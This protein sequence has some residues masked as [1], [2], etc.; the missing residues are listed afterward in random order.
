MNSSFL[1][2]KPAKKTDV[3]LDAV[4]GGVSSTG[5]TSNTFDGGFNGFDDVKGKLPV[6][7]PS[8]TVFDAGLAAGSS[9]AS[10]VDVKKAAIDALV[11]MGFSESNSKDALEK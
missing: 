9:S 10:A 5:K 7:A 4:F 2:G 1:S 6:P 11:G 3:D 8:T